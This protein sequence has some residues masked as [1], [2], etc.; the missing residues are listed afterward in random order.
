MWS[1]NI[2]LVGKILNR[3]CPLDFEG[4]QWV[5]WDLYSLKVTPKVFLSA[6][7]SLLMCY[8]RVLRYLSHL[9]VE[10]IKPWHFPRFLEMLKFKKKKSNFLSIPFSVPLFLFTSFYDNI[11]TICDN[12][13]KKKKDCDS[14]KW[15]VTRNTAVLKLN[16]TFFGIYF[17][18]FD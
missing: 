2:S 12:V 11:A 3:N 5:I 4:L 17:G 16:N 8:H 9:F 6:I 7:P 14:N 15:V 13:F 1:I 10:L 18:P